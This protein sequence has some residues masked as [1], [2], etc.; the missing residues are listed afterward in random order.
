MQWSRNFQKY[1]VRILKKFPRDDYCCYRDEC[2]LLEYIRKQLNYLH[3]TI[4]PFFA[5]KSHDKTNNV[6]TKVNLHSYG[7]IKER[8]QLLL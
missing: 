6:V 5:T 3:T 4:T 7:L 1:V 8:K 2:S